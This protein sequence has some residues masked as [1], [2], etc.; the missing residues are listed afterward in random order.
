MQLA[1]PQFKGS[2]ALNIPAGVQDVITTPRTSIDIGQYGIGTFFNAIMSYYSA[3]GLTP[4]VDNSQGEVE[5][6]GYLVDGGGFVDMVTSLNSRYGTIENGAFA[7]PGWAPDPGT[8]TLSIDLSNVE[9]NNVVQNMVIDWSV[10]IYRATQF[11]DA[12]VG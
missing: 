2:Y 12:S 8:L 11:V 5:L 1:D 9:A 3:D 4:S 7:T 6:A 10:V